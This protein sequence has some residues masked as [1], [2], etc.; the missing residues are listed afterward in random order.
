MMMMIPEPWGGD[1]AHEPE[2]RAFYEYHACLM[3]PWDGPASIAFTDGRR[4]GAVLDRNGLRPSRYYVTKDG[5]VI[6]A[7]EVGVLDVAA[8]GRAAQGPA[9]AGAHVPRRSGAGP[10]HRRRGAEAGHRHASSP[11]PSGCATTSSRWRT[12]PPAPVVHRARTTRS[13]AAAAAGVRLHLRG[14][15]DPAAADGADGQRGDRLDGQRRGPGRALGPAA[16]AL[17]LLQAALRPGDQPAGG[18]HPRGGHHVDGHD[19]RRRG[20]PAGADAAARP[21]RSS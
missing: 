5:L 10:D 15:E 13:R 17:Q 14:P 21:G 2:K 6:M 9:P 20:Q 4:I 7:S 19:H 12:C 1:A 18:L 3:E 11:T 8:G 16:A